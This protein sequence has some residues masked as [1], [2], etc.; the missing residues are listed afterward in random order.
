MKPGGKN[1]I[2]RQRNDDF[3]RSF[4]DPFMTSLFACLVCIPHVGVNSVSKTI[5][6]WAL[7][8]IFSCLDDDKVYTNQRSSTGSTCGHCVPT[9][10]LALTGWPSNSI[11]CTDSIWLGGSAH[12]TRFR[13]YKIALPPQTKTLEGR[14]PQ[15]DKHLPRSPL[16]GQ[17]F[18]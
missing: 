15:T 6:L 11:Y 4:M 16:K 9:S 8:T 5:S 2:K 12:F 14:G 3:S 17:Y 1:Y 13:T 10:I 18:R 7:I